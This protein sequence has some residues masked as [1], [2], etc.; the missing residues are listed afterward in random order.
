MAA[1]PPPPSPS[2]P[3]SNPGPNEEGHRGGGGSRQGFFK[4]GRGKQEPGRVPKEGGESKER[5]RK[6]F[7]NFF[8]WWNELAHD[9]CWTASTESR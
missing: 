9:V 4:E 2:P 1:P 5:E 3:L 8:F 7:S 6:R